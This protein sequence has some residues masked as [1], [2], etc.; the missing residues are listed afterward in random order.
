[1]KTWLSLLYS[2]MIEVN[3]L[4]EFFSSL[5]YVL[6]NNDIEFLKNIKNGVL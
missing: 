4:I 6:K 5:K 2:N 3:I 1:L